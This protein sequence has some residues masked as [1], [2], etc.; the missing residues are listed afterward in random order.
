MRAL[1]DADWEESI[2]DSEFIGKSPNL[3][4]PDERLAMMIKGCDRV[5]VATT[6]ATLGFLLCSVVERCI[7]RT[8]PLFP[9]SPIVVHYCLQDN[10]THGWSLRDRRA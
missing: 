2:D 3:F 9:S 4:G 6:D 1:L 8:R 5:R 7:K 10:S